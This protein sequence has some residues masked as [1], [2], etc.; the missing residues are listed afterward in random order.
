[1]STTHQL[2][3]TYEQLL[4]PFVGTIVVLDDLANRP[5]DCDILI[6][7]CPTNTQ[8]SYSRLV[9]P[10]TMLLLGLDYTLLRP[11]FNDV[12][13]RNFHERFGNS[14]PQLLIFMGGTD[15]YNSTLAILQALQT[16]HL[17]EKLQTTVLIGPNSKH[18]ESVNRFI[19]STKSEIDLICGSKEIA[20]LMTRMDLS[21][22]ASGS[23]SW[24]RCALGLPSITFAIVDNQLPTGHA[25]QKE[26]ASI[27]LGEWSESSLKKLCANVESLLQ[28][29]KGHRT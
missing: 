17:L 23:T 18:K 22:G 13:N 24:E 8:E 2:G 7:P 10:D 27:F 3:A 12:P 1:M 29:P 11:E 14:V 16:G 6:D 26:N 5:H 19:E 28:A 4:R 15:P 25:L 20:K 9:G 21:I